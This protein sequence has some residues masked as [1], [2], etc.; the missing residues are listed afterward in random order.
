MGGVTGAQTTEHT[1]RSITLGAV[2]A[3]CGFAP[4]PREK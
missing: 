1:A 4:L 3:R 2:D